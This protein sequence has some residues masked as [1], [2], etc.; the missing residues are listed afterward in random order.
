M[1]NAYLFI[2]LRRNNDHDPSVFTWVYWIT[3][4]LEISYRTFAKH[5]LDELTIFTPVNDRYPLSS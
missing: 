1:G 5:A 4:F 2:L 3:I